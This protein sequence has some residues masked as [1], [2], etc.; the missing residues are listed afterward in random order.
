MEISFF[1]SDDIP[2]PPQETRIVSLNAE[3]WPDGRRVGVE[4]QITPFQER[5]DLHIYIQNAQGQ[6]LASASAVQIR[7]PHIGFTLHL[8][9]PEA[10]GLYQVSALL[11]YP[12]PSP[13]LGVVDHATTTVQEP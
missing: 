12:D 6:E 9:G 11:V 4:V 2:V 1:D 5:P 3:L 7:Q 10:H 13:K 8:R